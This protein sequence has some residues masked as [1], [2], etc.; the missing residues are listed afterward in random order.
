MVS[1]KSA[2]SFTVLAQLLKL[3]YLA[4]LLYFI[5]YL[6]YAYF[7]RQFSES[8][9]VQY[10]LETSLVWF[11]K[12][13]A[14]WLVISPVVLWYLE[15]NKS[16]NRLFYKFSKVICFA[17]LISLFIRTLFVTGEYAS[18]SIATIV[19]VLPKYV[20]VTLAIVTGWFLF[21]RRRTSGDRNQQESSDDIEVLVESNGLKHSLQASD[22]FYVKSAG[23]YV[24]IFTEHNNYIQRTTLK[25]LLET[26]PNDSFA[27]V[28]RSFAVNLLK[29][30]K[31]S[32]S[33]NGSG[34]ITLKNQ[35]IIPVSKSYKSQLKSTVI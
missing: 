14:I 22:I 18:S 20:P 32:N 34:T 29:L 24:E 5:V 8:D 33:E 27:K 11:I 1:N 17:L 10:S 30:E 12:E 9:G 31:L 13:W 21:D 25:Q 23:N 4:W 7:W 15:V 2:F 6:G 19:F 26:L 16:N 28:H 3:N 35:Q